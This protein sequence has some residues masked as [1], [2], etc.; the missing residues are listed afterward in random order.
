LPEETNK[1][2]GSFKTGSTSNIQIYTTTAVTTQWVNT[3]FTKR[4]RHGRKQTSHV[5]P[6]KVHIPFL[7]KTLYHILKLARICAYP[8]A[9]A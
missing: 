7:L 9:M 3:L 2:L 4:F 6:S 5:N 1:N 8:R